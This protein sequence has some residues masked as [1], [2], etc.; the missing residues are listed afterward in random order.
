[1]ES[2]RL[3]LHLFLHPFALIAGCY[4]VHKAWNNRLFRD[5]LSFFL[6]ILLSPPFWTLDTDEER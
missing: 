2:S 3:I 6:D 5:Y 1:M 4:V